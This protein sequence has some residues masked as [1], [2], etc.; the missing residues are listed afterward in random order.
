MALKGKLWNYVY[1]HVIGGFFPAAIS[2]GFLDAPWPVLIALLVGSVRELFQ[3]L[4]WPWKHEP[5]TLATSVT[6]TAEFVLGGAIVEVL[7]A[8]LK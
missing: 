3:H 5:Q 6:N 8:F 7:V 4:N 2:A 1:G